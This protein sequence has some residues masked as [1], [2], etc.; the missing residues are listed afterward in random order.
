MLC[1]AGPISIRQ[2]ARLV[3]RDV[4]AVHSDVTALV[5]AGLI[6]RTDRAIEFPYDAIKV[7]FLLEAA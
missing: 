7:E 2:A 4:K 3:G 5:S 1:G 6:I